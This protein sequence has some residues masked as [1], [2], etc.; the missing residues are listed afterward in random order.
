MF[1]VFVRKLNV[2]DSNV[3]L[4]FLSNLTQIPS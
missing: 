4:F 3:V 2:V 1:L